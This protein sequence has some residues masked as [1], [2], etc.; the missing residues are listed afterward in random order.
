MSKVKIDPK[1]L[2]VWKGVNW[3]L[4]REGEVNID[5]TIRHKFVRINHRRKKLRYDD[6]VSAGYPHF[7]INY[8]HRFNDMYDWCDS[9][10][11]KYN[12]ISFGYTFFFQDEKQMALFM[13]RWG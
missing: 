13:L 3:T 11:G 5:N 4:M 8:G 2:V 10:F 6:F 12:V 7:Q 1:K 9:M